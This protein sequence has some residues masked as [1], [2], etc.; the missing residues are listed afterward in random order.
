MRSMYARVEVHYLYGRQAWEPTPNAYQQPLGMQA[1]FM[2]HTK[3]HTV[4]IFGTSWIWE[5]CKRQ[6]LS[7]LVKPT[8]NGTTNY[9]DTL[10]C[11][12]DYNVIGDWFSPLSDSVLLSSTPWKGKRYDTDSLHPRYNFI[13][14]FHPVRV[15]H[16]GLLV[17]TLH[18]HRQY[19]LWSHPDRST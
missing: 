18:H 14:C 9:D 8:T 17:P 2:G 1:E 12:R 4:W 15:E 10:L 16:W 7:Q 13:R 19:V 3:I 5:M 11:V 6:T